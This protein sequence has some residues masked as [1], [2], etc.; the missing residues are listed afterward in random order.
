[1]LPL[2]DVSR[3]D[4]D[5]ADRQAAGNP[6]APFAHSIAR[7]LQSQWRALANMLRGKE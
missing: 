1:M 4:P 3:P 7:V 5:P 6:F 2:K